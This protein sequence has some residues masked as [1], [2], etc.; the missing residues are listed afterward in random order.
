MS[1]KR[2]TI[3]QVK[4]ARA[5]HEGSILSAVHEEDRETRSKRT[6]KC[7]SDLQ[8]TNLTSNAHLSGQHGKNG[9]SLDKIKTAY[10]D[11]LIAFSSGNI[12]NAK[13]NKQVKKYF[14]KVQGYLFETDGDIAQMK[15]QVKGLSDIMKRVKNDYIQTLLDGEEK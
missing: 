9:K 5:S 6:G 14:T 1:N 4:A 10:N 8:T 3:Q 12:Y 2:L 13:A 15:S 7:P 11:D